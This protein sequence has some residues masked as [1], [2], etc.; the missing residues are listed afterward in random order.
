[1]DDEAAVPGR[2]IGALFGRARQDDRCVGD[3]GPRRV[4]DRDR[5]LGGIL[6]RGRR[7]RGQGVEGRRDQR[8]E[9]TREPAHRAFIRRRRPS[10]GP[11]AS[12]TGRGVSS[13]TV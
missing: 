7:D 5:E 11:T 13:T 9:Y 6:G 4:D 10:W 8:P 12:A 3:A 2:R 1:A